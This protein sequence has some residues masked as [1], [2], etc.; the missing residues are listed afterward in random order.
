MRDTFDVVNHT[1]V[2][3]TILGPLEKRVLA[4][5]AMKTPNWVSPN[6]L[7]LV[8][9]L[10]AILICVGYWLCRINEHFLWLSSFGWVCNWYGDSLDGTLA[11]LRNIE[12]P[13]YGFYVDHNV[14][15]LS[16][17]LVAAGFGL[18]PYIR[19]DTALLAL[20]AYLLLNIQM[21]THACATTVFRISYLKI[22]ATEVRAFGV[23][24]NVVLYCSDYW[25]VK[26]TPYGLSP[27]DVVSLFLSG[28]M[29]AAFGAA[30]LR[31]SVQLYRSGQ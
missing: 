30:V 25:Q 24:M 16:E 4:F 8:G 18:S 6:T 31:H 19:L 29:L 12:R 3:V 22:G 26:W 20:A 2:N 21:Y 28:V 1:R 7:T 11:R 9:F 13:R 15:A 14:D 23:L 17:M 5:L 10:G 27:V